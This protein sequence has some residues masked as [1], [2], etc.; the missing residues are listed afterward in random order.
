V[1]FVEIGDQSQHRFGF[2]L[3]VE[4]LKRTHLSGSAGSWGGLISF[5]ERVNRG[6]FFI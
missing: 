6:S 3:F 2:Y 1:G 5:E 4:L